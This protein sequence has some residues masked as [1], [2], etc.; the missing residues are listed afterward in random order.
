MWRTNCHLTKSC[1]LLLVCLLWVTCSIC[2]MCPC[3]GI[4]S[5]R[6]FTVIPSLRVERNL[7]GQGADSSSILHSWR[8]SHRCPQFFDP[9]K[10]HGSINS[11]QGV[12]K[13]CSVMLKT[14]SLSGHFHLCHIDLSQGFLP[15]II[16]LCNLVLEVCYTFVLERPPKACIV[17]AWSLAW[18]NARKWWAL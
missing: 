7:G 10:S 16:R 14:E 12:S 6:A 15:N 3:S 9:D 4:Q 13:N 18:S 5:A 8:K 11:F 2:S 1:F 17:K